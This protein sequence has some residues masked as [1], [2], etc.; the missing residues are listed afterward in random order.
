MFQKNTVQKSEATKMSKSSS[1][2]SESR[3][4]TWGQH[5]RQ[6]ILRCSTANVMIELRTEHGTLGEHRENF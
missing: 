6:L 4:A 1:Q 2:P 3:A 5:T